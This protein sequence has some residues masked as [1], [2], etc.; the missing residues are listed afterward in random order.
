MGYHNA[1][2]GGESCMKGYDGVV[3]VLEVLF[4]CI[5]NMIVSCNFIVIMMHIK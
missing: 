1:L 4:D 3:M 2:L 5:D